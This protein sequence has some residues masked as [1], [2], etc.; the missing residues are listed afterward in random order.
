[1]SNEEDTGSFPCDLCPETFEEFTE[2]SEHLKSHFK[3]RN[4]KCPE[5]VLEFESRADLL[6]HQATHNVGPTFECAMCKKKFPTSL[7]LENHAIIHRD[8]F[9]CDFCDKIFSLKA[10]L[11]DHK[12][13][14]QYKYKCC[15][16]NRSLSGKTPFDNHM[17]SLHIKGGRMFHCDICSKDFRSK[18][19][20]KQHQ[21]SHEDKP[22]VCETCGVAYRNKK[23]FD[24]HVKIHE[25]GGITCC[26]IC[27][28]KAQGPGS[29]S[30]HMRMHEKELALLKKLDSSSVSHTQS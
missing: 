21:E 11:H 24:I 15:L 12:K 19:N 30:Q 7:A 1:M 9:S 5:C 8:K 2:F 16:C 27:K 4:H 14:F 29:L 28:F 6:E 23:L 25:E 17:R 20:L 26:K 10:Q 3:G 22:H 18:G 13:L